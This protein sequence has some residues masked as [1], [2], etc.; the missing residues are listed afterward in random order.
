MIIIIRA[1]VGGGHSQCNK[2]T[3]RNRDE[4]NVRRFER[5]ITNAF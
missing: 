4:V 3:E 1:Q 5:L 2:T